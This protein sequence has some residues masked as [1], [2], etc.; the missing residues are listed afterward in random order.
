MPLPT[1]GTVKTLS[2]LL[3]IDAHLIQFYPNAK[4]P[5][6]HF[7]GGSSYHVLLNDLR[8]VSLLFLSKDDNPPLL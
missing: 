8:T 4:E 6:G 2:G 5:P 1:L 3:A 7:S